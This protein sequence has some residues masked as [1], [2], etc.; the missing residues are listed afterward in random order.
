M[1]NALLATAMLALSLNVGIA[2]AAGNATQVSIV[3]VD[4]R[5]DGTFLVTF[6][7]PTTTAPSCATEL[8][9][10]S[11]YTGS[12]GGRAVL[13]AA[14][15][16]FASGSRVNAQGMGSCSEFAGIESILILS[17]NR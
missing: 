10:M 16:A 4:A 17:Q 15:L 12:P 2:R 7:Q 13:A 8:L 6:S 14:M 1:N 9:R 11:G 5:A 3:N